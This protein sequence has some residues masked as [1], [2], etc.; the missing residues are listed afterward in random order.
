MLSYNNGVDSLCSHLQGVYS[1][2]R[3]A[4]VKELKNTVGIS[5]VRGKH[6]RGNGFITCGM[7]W[8]GALKAFWRE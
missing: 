8:P 2:T 6:H 3:A 5:F 4:G 1:L 7:T